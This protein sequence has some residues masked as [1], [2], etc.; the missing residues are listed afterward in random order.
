MD[1]NVALVTGQRERTKVAAGKLAPI[2]DGAAWLLGPEEKQFNGPKPFFPDEDKLK[3][4]TIP[5]GIAA[6]ALL[7]GGVASVIVDRNRGSWLA[8][9]P[10]PAAPTPKPLSLEKESFVPIPYGRAPRLLS[11]DKSN[12]QVRSW[13][14]SGEP[15]GVASPL[16]SLR[17]DATTFAQLSEG[18]SCEWGS[19]SFRRLAGKEPW[20][21]GIS[22]DRAL[23]FK[24]P[25][26]DATTL[27]CSATEVVV[28]STTLDPLDKEKK[29]KIPQL[30]RCTL[31]G[32][33]AEPKTP[34]FTLWTEK[35]DHSIAVVPTERG[36]VSVMRAKS[37]PRW[38]L[39]LGQSNDGGTNFELQRVIGEG[40]DDKRVLELG[41][42][43]RF[44]KR[45]VMLISADVG[46]TGRRGWYAL[47]SDD[48]GN[49]W[50]PP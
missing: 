11:V 8:Y 5:G 9:S 23:A 15:L 50:G 20:V 31:D 35:H 16:P 47:A 1:G 49:N 48:D 17:T 13:P 29:R 21:I 38:A 25:A 3:G 33:C 46:A 18:P 7:E 30:V 43:I 2:I 41:A 45:L 22:G 26:A 19:F 14:K 32:K 6:P 34:P 42:L 12:V 39:Y 36:L 10:T 4:A 37:G 40:R 24:V 44:P 27:G 28:E